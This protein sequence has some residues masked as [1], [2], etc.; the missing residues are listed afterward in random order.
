MSVHP[1]I[2]HLSRGLVVAGIITAGLALPSPASAA[3]PTITRV[4]GN[5]SCASLGAGFR[6]VK[7]EPV[8]QGT[9][10]FDGGSITVDG[11][12]FDWSTVEGVDAVIVKGGPTANVYRFAA[13][14]TSGTDF[15]APTNPSSGQP[16]GLSHISFCFDTDSE[17]TPPA[18]APGPCEEGGPTTMPN[19]QPCE[20]EQPAPCEPGGPTTMP[21]GQPCVAEEPAPCEAG[22]PTTMPNGQP[23][24][25]EEPAGT[26][27]PTPPPAQQVTPVR[28]TEPSVVVPA[29]VV[30]SAA[31]SQ[32]ESRVLGARSTVA[33]LV[34][35]TA[36]MTGP[37]RCVT[38]SFRQVI[39]GTG[40]RRI[41]VRVNGKV[42]KTLAGG[43][44]RYVVRVQP[45]SG[46]QRITARVTFVAA[47]GKRARTLRSTVLRCSA[48]AVQGVRF[49]G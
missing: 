1:T 40:I 43:R 29:P 15:S 42:V 8:R 32:G 18:P 46:V 3:E 39:T 38:R 49:A 47:S 34:A 16:Y 25:A 28:T 17:P 26:P 30:S 13:E 10:S 44:K 12:V 11:V 37:K 2:Q 27:A 19:G 20:A 33:R 35:A 14:S 24:E 9:T 22:G 21:N 6:E 23:C 41:V 36:R 48:G 7:L 5:P 31:S 45:R 4:D